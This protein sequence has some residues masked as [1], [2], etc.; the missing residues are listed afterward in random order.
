VSNEKPKGSDGLCDVIL[1]GDVSKQNVGDTN[2]A[3]TLSLPKLLVRLLDRNQ[4]PKVPLNQGS[5][6]LSDIKAGTWNR[7]L[8]RLVIPSDS[9][10]PDYKVLIFS[11]RKGDPLPVTT[12]NSDHTKL[13][14]SWSDQEDELTFAKTP[15]GKNDLTI[16]RLKDGKSEELIA[17]NRP[18]VLLPNPLKEDGHQSATNAV[19]SIDAVPVAD[20]QNAIG[21]STTAKK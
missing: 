13:H 19:S 16:I 7:D 4:D 9:E 11:H 6:Y 12:W 3:S 20:S 1:Q 14:V 15:I 5:A 2:Q 18:V 17:M 8:H 10:S 21:S